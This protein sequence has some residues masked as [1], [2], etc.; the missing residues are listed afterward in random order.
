V[1]DL[2]RFALNQATVRAWSLRQAIE[3]CARHGVKRIG[4]WRDKLAECGLGEARRLLRDHGLTVTGLN[5]AGPFF[6]VG[7]ELKPSTA[8]DDRRAIAE[9]AEIGAECLLVFPGVDRRVGDLARSRALTA[10]RIG[11]LL[12]EARR[13][14]VTLAIEPLHPML[15]GDR[16]PFNSLRQA[17]ILCDELGSGL[18]IV[19]DAYHSWWDSDLDRQIPRAGSRLLG[20]HICDWLAPTRDLYQDRGMM[21][22]GVIDLAGLRQSLDAAGYAGS[23]EVDLRLL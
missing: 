21:G 2:S 3:G 12:P 7:T 14:G 16:S 9:A 18:G 19:L 11:S 4:V 8:D 17:N 15:A 6:G 20:F 13:A 5:R 23:I 10:E 1:T 22:D